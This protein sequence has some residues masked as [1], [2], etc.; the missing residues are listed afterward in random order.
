MSEYSR[1]ITVTAGS[2]YEY[3]VSVG[4]VYWPMT[5]ACS[6]ARGIEVTPE[7]TAT[8]TATPLIPESPTETL[9]IT[10]TNTQTRT[11]TWTKTLTRTPTVTRTSTPI[12]V[13]ITLEF[14]AGD[15]YRYS[16]SPHP[17]FRIKNKGTGAIDV[18]KLEIRYWYKYDGAIKP[19]QSYID[20][21]GINGS[22]ITEKVNINIVSG[23]FGSG[24]DRYVKVTFKTKAGQLGNGINDYLEV[25]TRFNKIDWTQYDQANDWSFTTYTSFTIWDRVVVYYNGMKVYGIEP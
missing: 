24:Q 1:G 20:W 6:F 17:Q 2:V 19:E 11:A 25:N 12:P 4:N 8:I 7:A 3:T 16:A 9:T 23:N 10:K 14:K 15:V 21:A 13:K 18:S 22:P 5:L